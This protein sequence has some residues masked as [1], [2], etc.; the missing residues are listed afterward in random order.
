MGCWHGCVA[1]VMLDLVRN[2]SSGWLLERGCCQCDVTDM[3][4][5]LLGF[6]ATSHL[7]GLVGCVVVSVF[8]VSDTSQSVR[9]S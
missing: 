6:E 8:P 4:G 9:D 1:V 2:G 3:F 5:A 7:T